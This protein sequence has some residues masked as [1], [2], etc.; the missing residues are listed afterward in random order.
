MTSA[1][2]WQPLGS[3][4]SAG[5]RPTSPKPRLPRTYYTHVSAYN[6]VE[7]HGTE[8][9]RPPLVEG[10]LTH[11]ASDAFVPRANACHVGAVCHVRSATE[12]VG[13]QI[14]QAQHRI[15]RP[16]TNGT[17]STSLLSAGKEYAFPL[18]YGTDYRPN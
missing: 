18:D 4:K 14:L 15:S 11:C 6:E 13:S 12:L 10:V 5:S 17:A 3:R 7:L 16:Q 9:A 8:A 1:A 2:T